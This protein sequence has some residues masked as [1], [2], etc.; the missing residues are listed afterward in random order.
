MKVGD[1]VKYYGSWTSVG[2][3]LEVYKSRGEIQVLCNEKIVWWVASGC[4]VI[5]ES[6]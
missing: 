3:V 5:D 2:V 1:L 4:E 6:R